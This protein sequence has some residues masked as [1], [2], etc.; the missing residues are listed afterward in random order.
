MV[1]RSRRV[2]LLL[3]APQPFRIGRQRGWQDLDRDVTV[4]ARIAG[5]IDF[6]HPASA[7][8][9]GNEIR[10]KVGA[11]SE[12]HACRDYTGIRPQVRFSPTST[13]ARYFSLAPAHPEGPFSRSSTTPAS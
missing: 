1:E 8:K 6:T 2:R 4:Q 7:Q 10:A 3:E 11:R 12:R 13:R 5:A 9:V